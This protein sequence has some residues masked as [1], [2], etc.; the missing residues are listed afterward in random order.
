M[1][2]SVSGHDEVNAALWLAI[3]EGKTG[4]SCAPGISGRPAPIPDWGLWLAGKTIEMET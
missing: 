4:L 1:T 3:V 2:G